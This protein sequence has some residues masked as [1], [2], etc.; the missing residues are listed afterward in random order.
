MSLRSSAQSSFAR[1]ALLC[2]VLTCS[3]PAF[4]ESPRPDPKAIAQSFVDELQAIAGSPERLDAVMLRIYGAKLPADKVA[5][6]SEQTRRIWAHA[7]F[8]PYLR[9]LLVPLVKV[10]AKPAD[11]NAAALEA[12]AALSSKGLLRMPVE[13]Q[14]QFI[15]LSILIFE[16]M[17]PAQC[18][19]LTNDEYSTAQAVA[20]ERRVLVGLPVDQFAAVMTLYADSAEAELNEYPEVRTLSTE[21]ASLSEKV[22]DDALDERLGADLSPAALKRV[23]KDITTAPAGEVCALSIASIRAIEDMSEPYRTWKVLRFLESVQ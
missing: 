4:A 11:M 8:G 3:A 6:A 21:Q 18:K 1:I 17:P 12:L 13:R 22:Y 7:A 15:R 2:A 23:A 5:I 20:I 14:R 16:S 10:K 19:K 9:E